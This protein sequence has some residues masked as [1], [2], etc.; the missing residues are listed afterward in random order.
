[1]ENDQNKEP[2]LIHHSE[3]KKRFVMKTLLRESQ[4]AWRFWNVL[5][6]NGIA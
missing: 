6:L 5:D 2:K 3:N 1:M 4:K